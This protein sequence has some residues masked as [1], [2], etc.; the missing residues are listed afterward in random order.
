[1]SIYSKHI[2]LSLSTITIAVGVVAFL[3]NKSAGMMEEE[4]KFDRK[5]TNINL[6]LSSVTPRSL[7][8]TAVAGVKDNRLYFQTVYPNKVL[9][10]D[11]DFKNHV[12]K[13]LNV[14]S[15]DTT[16]SMFTLLLKDNGL[17][18]AASNTPALFAADEGSASTRMYHF[19]QRSFTRVVMI[20]PDSY[21][22]RGRDTAV[23]TKDQTFFKGSPAAGITGREDNVSKKVG[24]YGMSTDGIL[25]YDKTSNLIVYVPFYGNQFIC[26]D[27]NLHKKYEVTTVNDKSKEINSIGV[28]DAQGQK[29]VTNVGP[30]RLLNTYSNVHD[31]T[32]YIKSDARSQLQPAATFANNSTID[33][34]DIASGRY[35]GS[36]YIPDHQGEKPFSF[37]VT[38]QSVIALY[39]SSA[40]NWHINN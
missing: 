38:D 35:K 18:I 16:A 36:F 8:M 39:K 27:T 26:L 4:T 17:T 6:I 5:M 22:F 12:E 19:P 30:K 32:L 10:T 21:V 9:V 11:F 28:T 34:Y 37:R 14:P 25:D 33:M 24:D 15:D 7:M 3:A 23:K 40:V 1:M 2:V 20:A 29:M 31:G 13:T